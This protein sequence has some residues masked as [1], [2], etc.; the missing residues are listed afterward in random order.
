MQ[1]KTKQ[2]S[3][4]L[5]AAVAAFTAM[6]AIGGNAHAGTATSN[7]SVTATVAANC[8]IDASGTVAFGTYDPIV[9]NAAAD[10]DNTGSIDTVCTNG[11]TPKITLGQGANADTGSTADIPL[12]RMT[13]GTN[14]L[15]YQLYSEST[16]TTIWGD[17]AATGLQVTGTG[18]TVNTPVYGRVTQG[19]NVPAGS[20]TDTVVAT[21][22]F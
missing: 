4:K 12:R 6:A 8:T 18:A 14:F 1:A 16:R 9:A 3:F 17:T 19:Q 11:S 22:T 13:D 20:Y 5:A 2:T 10:L 7:L 15:S 21:I